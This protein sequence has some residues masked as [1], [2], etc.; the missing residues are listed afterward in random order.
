MDAATITAILSASGAFLVAV[1]TAF[2]SLRKT[3]VES[4]VAQNQA[5]F[6]ALANRLKEVEDDL[7]QEK[8]ISDELRR[9]ALENREAL[10]LANR[11]ISTLKDQL[12]VASS[13]R[14][15]ERALRLEVEA[16]MG[17]VVRRFEERIAILERTSLEFISEASE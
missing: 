14:D 9:E 2:F 3:V 12:S 4:T 1:V 17:R 5:F 11:E 6:V 10:S 13:Q 8:I 16:E 15:E 7:A